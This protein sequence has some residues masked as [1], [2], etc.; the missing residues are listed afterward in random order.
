VGCPTTS[1]ARQSPPKGRLRNGLL[2]E[3]AC[4]RGI[5]NDIDHP[6]RSLPAGLSPPCPL[7]SPRENRAHPAEPSSSW[8]GVTCSSLPTTSGARQSPPKGRLRNGL[9]EESA[10]RRGI[11]DDID[12]PRRSLH[13]DVEEDNDGRRRALPSRA[14]D[15]SS[16]GT[17]SDVQQGEMTGASRPPRHH[18]VIRHPTSSRQRTVA[19]APLGRSKVSRM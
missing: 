7:C 12:H 14:Y 4:R 11:Q 1:G 10:C 18:D 2:K 8:S 19:K 6:R 9:L 3:S 16:G 15:Q 5:Q 17:R 13:R